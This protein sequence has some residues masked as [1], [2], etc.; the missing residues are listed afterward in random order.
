MKVIVNL[1]ISFKIKL[2]NLMNLLIKLR[3]TNLKQ[4]GFVLIF[5]LKIKALNIYEIRINYYYIMI[6]FN[7]N[8]F[9]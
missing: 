4:K 9:L 6:Y 3:L 5:L 1:M 8:K 7:V 2:A